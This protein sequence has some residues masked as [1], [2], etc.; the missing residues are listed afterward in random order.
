MI[1]LPPRWRYLRGWPTTTSRRRVDG[2]VEGIKADIV[3]CCWWEG[4]LV[5]EIG[6]RK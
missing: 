1:A 2:R 3:Y 6:K 5:W 4:G